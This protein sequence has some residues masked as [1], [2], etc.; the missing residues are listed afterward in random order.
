VYGSEL[1]GFN[2]CF[3]YRYTTMKILNYYYELILD[4]A[5]LRIT[6]ESLNNI[7]YKG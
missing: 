1:D 7:L 6:N 2:Y 4:K 5:Y 3:D